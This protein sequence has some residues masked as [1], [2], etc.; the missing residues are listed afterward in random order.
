MKTIL[1]GFLTALLL[2]PALAAELLP[3][4]FIRAIDGDTIVVEVQGHEERIRLIGIDTPEKD[5]EWGDVATAMTAGFC[6]QCPNL[7][8]EMDVQ[9]R[10]RYGRLLA[11][12]WC[13]RSNIMLN[14]ALV[15]EG[16]ALPTTY[17][18]NVRHVER[19]QHALE[20]AKKFKTGFWKKGGLEMTP[21]EWRRYNR[22]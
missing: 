4:H 7:E 21:G 19:F 6:S 5:Q 8:L 2:T 10:D 12:V 13:G 1:A 16:V 18:P 14:E 3:I 17:P 11:Y 22:L 20:V 15:V 9:E